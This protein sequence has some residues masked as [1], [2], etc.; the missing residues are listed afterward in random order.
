MRKLNFWGAGIR[1]RKWGR[2]VSPLNFILTLALVMLVTTGAAFSYHKIQTLI[3]TQFWVQHTLSVLS[4]VEAT[5]ASLTNAE[6]AIHR[7]ILSSDSTTLNAYESETANLNSDFERLRALMRDNPEQQTRLELMA[8]SLAELSGQLKASVESRRHNDTALAFR[9]LAQSHDARDRVE[10]LLAAMSSEEQ[11]LLRVRIKEANS[12]GVI[13][14]SSVILAA[15]LVIDFMLFAWYVFVKDLQRT[16]ESSVSADELASIV[17]WSQDAIVA[18][19]LDGTIRA[20]NRGA[21]QIY[22]FAAEEVIG[23]PSS[24]FV[25]S[26]RL[27]EMAKILA[28]V[29]NGGVIKDFETVRK[30]KNGKLVDVSVTISPIRDS[31]G[32]VV[33]SSAIL[34]D[35]TLQKRA[36]EA[37]KR[38][39]EQYRL[40]FYNSPQPMWVFDIE[41]LRFLAVNEAA[42]RHYGYLEQEFLQMTILDIRPP[43]DIPKLLQVVARQT[44]GLAE[45]GGWRHRTKAGKILNA[46]VTTH[47]ITFQERPA[48]LV[49]VS[50]V[51]ERTE[52][53]E[54]LR[55]SEERFSKAFRSSPLAMTISTRADGLLMD[56]N[57]AFLNL[58]GYSYEESI[59]H[60][61]AELGIWR[62]KDD[63]RIL[64][65]ELHR[66]GRV[67]AFESELKAKSGEI[68]KAVIS[69]EPID[70]EGVP[71]MLTITNDITEAERMETQ[72]RQAQ[73][74]EAVGRLAGGVAHDFN[75]LLGVIS[76]YSELLASQEN[77]S[78]QGRNRVAEIQK[79]VKR[80]AGLTRQLLAFSRKQIIEPQVLNLNSVIA[81]M[82]SMLGRMIG[83][84]VEL[85]FRPNAELGTIRADSGQMEQILMNLAVNAR[86]AMPKGGRL[87]IETANTELDEHYARRHPTLSPGPYVML[88]V[89]DTG[90]GMSKDVMPHIF[91]PFF[92]TKP[93]GK[94][95]GLGLSTVYG[96]VKQSRGHVFVYSELGRGTTFKIYLPQIDAPAV[97]VDQTIGRHALPTGSETILL[98]EDD[99]SLRNAVRDLLKRQGYQVLV[100]EQATTALS[101]AENSRDNLQLLLTDAVMPGTN[102]VELAHKIQV[103]IPGIGVLLMSGYAGELIENPSHRPALPLLQKPFTVNALL[104]KVREVLANRQMHAV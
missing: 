30:T 102:G 88:S 16:W 100:A 59:G 13:A 72:L 104:N 5:T 15:I 22:G 92:T 79:S 39:E 96:I 98:V 64:I 56:V 20:W 26:D 25:P 91:E 74:L 46:D 87:L 51:T 35:I 21:E 67:K 73:R 61:T 89:S 23:K 41:T 94:G 44:R 40:L 82:S 36:E 68:R 84:D 49:L 28:K 78:D 48:R 9:E 80:A 95:T 6:S 32:Q 58:C 43:E 86:Y 69:A 38:S 7:A 52:H 55:R 101:I 24:I 3:Q 11:S 90:V 93:E 31:R 19:A 42:V 18:R 29:R 60:T 8:Q 50:D 2:G 81:G 47:A 4:E 71:C 10:A 63:R 53:L 97:S 17:N 77:I 66:N 12:A 70:I 34:R 14:K 62:R 33:G 85:V 54:R 65:Q 75:N 76:A 27:N 45:S 37:L 83:E 1:Q 99:E 103:L 57:D